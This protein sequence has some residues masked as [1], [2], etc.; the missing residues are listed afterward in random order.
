M[1]SFVSKKIVMP[2]CWGL[3]GHTWPFGRYTVT[4]KCKANLTKKSI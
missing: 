2:E 3:N 4:R 1:T